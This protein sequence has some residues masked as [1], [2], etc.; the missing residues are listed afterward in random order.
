MSGIGPSL[1]IMTEDNVL[2]TT[3][4]E[5]STAAGDELTARGRPTSAEQLAI[6]PAN[7]A[8]W[9][10]LAAIFGT[11]DYPGQCQCQRFKVTRFEEVSRPTVRRAVMRI[12]FEPAGF[13]SA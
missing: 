9:D 1:W 8:S 3:I 12:D 13:G 7:E 2:D 4:H 10:D 5:P 11:N 6:A